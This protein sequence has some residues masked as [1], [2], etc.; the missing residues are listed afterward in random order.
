MWPQTSSTWNRCVAGWAAT[1]PRCTSSS[2]KVCSRGPARSAPIGNGQKKI[3]TPTSC[4]GGDGSQVP[5]IRRKILPTKNLEVFR[6]V[7]V[8]PGVR[9]E[10]PLPAP[11]SARCGPACSGSIRANFL[12]TKSGLTARKS[13]LGFT[14]K[15]NEVGSSQHRQHR[16]WRAWRDIACEE[17]TP[18]AAAASSG[19]CRSSAGAAGIQQREGRG[20]HWMYHPLRPFPAMPSAWRCTPHARRGEWRCSRSKT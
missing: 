17:T 20:P 5:S 7:R 8:W 6:R 1:S 15:Q 19:A 11:C 10:C 14:P 2:V 12:P 18:A 3:G 9:R 4:S 16:C 13:T